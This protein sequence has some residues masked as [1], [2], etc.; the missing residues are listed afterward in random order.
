M[1]LS[2]WL[3]WKTELLLG[4]SCMEVTIRRLGVAQGQE[5]CFFQGTHPTNDQFMCEGRGE[6]FNYQVFSGKD[7]K[8]SP[9]WKFTN[10]TQRN[11]SEIKLILAFPI[12]I[13]SKNFLWPTPS[14]HWL[15]FHRTALG[16]ADLY[17]SLFPSLSLCPAWRR[18]WRYMISSFIP[19]IWIGPQTL[20]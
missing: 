16:R 14:E 19:Q 5:P 20:F 2:G 1:T 6:G 11:P 15:V 12:F 7:A 4:R 10:H 13:W 3:A 8:L 17:I 18:M 9:P